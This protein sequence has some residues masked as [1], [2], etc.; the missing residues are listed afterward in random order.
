MPRHPSSTYGAS[1]SFGPGPL[2]TLLK[3]L[4]AANVALFLANPYDRPLP[5]VMLDDIRD[6]I[7]PRTAPVAVIFFL[8]A[9]L[10]CLLQAAAQRIHSYFALR[11]FELKK[12]AQ[13]TSGVEVEA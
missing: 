11:R 10:L 1:F 3:A 4:V 13:I 2:S 7:N 6:Q 12:D 8:A 9:V 5:V